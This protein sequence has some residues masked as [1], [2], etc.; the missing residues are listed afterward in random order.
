MSVAD[1]GMPAMTIDVDAQIEN[2]RGL[3]V[4]LEECFWSIDEQTDPSTR[5][6]LGVAISEIARRMGALEE[7]IRHLRSDEVGIN[8][9]IDQAR[10]IER[11]LRVLDGEFVADPNAPDEKM[12]TRVRALLEAAD[13]VLLATARGSA[14][15]SAEPNGILRPG[16]VLPLIRSSR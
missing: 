11:A 9:S 1:R 5:Y 15:R 6:A 3:K 12:W 13:D 16:I 4:D 2:L 10:T 14:I 8:A 7:V